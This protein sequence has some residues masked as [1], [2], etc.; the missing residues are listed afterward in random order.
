MDNIFEDIK[1]AL[2]QTFKGLFSAYDVFCEDM[3]RTEDLAEDWVF[4]ELV[5]V[6]NQTVSPDHT[7]RRVLVEVSIHMQAETNA[8]YLAIMPAVDALIRP[9]FCFGDRAITVDNLDMKVVDKVLHCTFTLAFRDSREELPP[10]DPYME[11]L[12]MN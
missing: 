11:T 8:G 5:P 1:T 3:E 7:D 6:G 4:I 2:L 9:A 10:E 12:T